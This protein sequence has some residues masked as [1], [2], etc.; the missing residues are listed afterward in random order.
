MPD[1]LVKLAMS[2]KNTVVMF[3]EGGGAY[4]NV[5][6]LFLMD[7]STSCQLF[8]DCLSAEAS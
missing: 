5:F 6:H 3:A 2:S 4:Y 1:S 7:L 8:A